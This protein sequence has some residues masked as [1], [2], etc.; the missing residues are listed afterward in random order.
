MIIIAYNVVQFQDTQEQASKICSK[1][2]MLED[3]KKISILSRVHQKRIYMFDV[4]RQICE[5]LEPNKYHW[6]CYSSVFEFA[7]T[8]I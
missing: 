4:E 2:R 6:P 3:V 1:E 7:K 5:K 8:D